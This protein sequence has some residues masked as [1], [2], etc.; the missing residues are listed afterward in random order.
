V[1]MSMA[2]FARFLNFAAA[3]QP[4]DSPDSGHTSANTGCPLISEVLP[5]A[6]LTR[7]ATL[8]HRKTR[9][10][11]ARSRYTQVDAIIR[12]RRH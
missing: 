11:P 9:D 5:S 7:C 12:E 1:R 8:I 6:A 4:R 3:R 2:A 10:F